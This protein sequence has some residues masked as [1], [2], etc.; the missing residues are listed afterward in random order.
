MSRELAKNPKLCRVDV[1]LLQEVEG[2]PENR[3]RAVEGLA[4]ALSLP[5]QHTA[6]NP[7]GGAT[8]NGLV[9]LSRFP[10]VEMSVLPLKR[11]DLVVN[12]RRR[13]ALVQTVESP[14]GRIRL[15]NLHLDTRINSQ[16]RLEQIEPIIAAAEK[17]TAPTVIG[18]DF[19]TGHFLWLWHIMPVSLWEDQAGAVLKRLSPLG[20]Q[21]PFI[22]AGPTHDH[23]GLRLDWFFLRGLRSFAHGI[24]KLDFTDHHA[25]WVEI[26]LP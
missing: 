5:F 8:G 25:I 21:T 12:N 4:L 20:F 22:G 16:S 26:G 18:G 23:F 11:F 24:E 2:Q 10:L 19:N 15:F 13:I 17:G 7:R 14:I 9:T 1:L 3:K 6:E